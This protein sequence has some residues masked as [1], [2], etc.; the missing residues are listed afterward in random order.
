[1]KVLILTAMK[2]EFDEVANFLN[3]SKDLLYE[4][5][6][7]LKVYYKDLEVTLAR[8]GIGKVNAAFRTALLLGKD[9]YNY[10]I[11]VGL[12]G[13]LSL[14]LKVGDVVYVGE[15]LQ[16]DF[17]FEPFGGKEGRVPGYPE[18]LLSDIPNLS[19]TICCTSDKF[20][21]KFRDKLKL[22]HK[23]KADVCDMEL[24]AIAHVCSWQDEPPE[25]FAIKVISDSLFGN[26]KEF[27]KNINITRLFIPYLKILL[28]SLNKID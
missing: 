16:S 28:D 4:S 23:F 25:V 11:N 21:E 1:M 9:N 24:A 7:I 15:T 6:N 19:D 2:R 5:E 14:K 12:A 3:T 10:V 22:R 20:V 27:V 17:S 13:G 26:Y 8:T 18:I